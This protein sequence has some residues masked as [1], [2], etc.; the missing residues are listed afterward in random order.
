[1]NRENAIVSF[2]QGKWHCDNIE[3]TPQGV[4][5]SSYEETMTIKDANTL[6]ITAHDFRDGEDLKKDM[7]IEVDGEEVVMSQGDFTAKG[8]YFGNRAQL[9][10]PDYQGHRIEI[11]LRFIADTFIYQMDVLKED[12]VVR[13]QFSYLNR[14]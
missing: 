6:S 7:R 12:D 2:L 9:V 3:I 11:H 13:C 8:T 5:R 4:N 14:Q 10:N 1:M